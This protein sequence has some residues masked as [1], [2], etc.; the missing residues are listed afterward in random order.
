LTLP[1]WVT[2][3]FFDDFLIKTSESTISTTKIYK[4]RAGDEA[5]GSLPQP[6]VNQW[7]M[8]KGPPTAGGRPLRRHRVLVFCRE[9]VRLLRSCSARPGAAHGLAALCAVNPDQWRVVKF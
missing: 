1:N 9:G 2:D 7:G 8:K 4:L 5:V 3:R 6:G